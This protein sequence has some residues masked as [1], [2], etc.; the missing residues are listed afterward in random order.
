LTS[1]FVSASPEV[2]LPNSNCLTLRRDITA[3][4]LTKSRDS[5]Y[6]F[7]VL[8]EL[9]KG[10]ELTVCGAGFNHRTVTVRWQDDNYYVFEQDLV[11]DD[12]TF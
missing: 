1:T 5:N 9:P 3:L 10:A 11:L 8:T 2:I 6:D 4:R 7:A 12:L